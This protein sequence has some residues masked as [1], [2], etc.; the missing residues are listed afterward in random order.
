MCNGA[1][2]KTKKQRG[3]ERRERVGNEEG[4]HEWLNPSLETPSRRQDAHTSL[5]F[6]LQRE[7]ED[8]RGHARGR[9]QRGGAE[10]SQVQRARLWLHETLVGGNQWLECSQTWRE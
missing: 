8:T 6:S 5:S 1:E 3:E 7:R 4:T 9:G 10:R 2:E